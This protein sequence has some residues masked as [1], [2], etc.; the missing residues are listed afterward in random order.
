M[1]KI[2][3]CIN[4]D[5]DD[6]DDDDSDVCAIV[7]AWMQYWWCSS[8]STKEE[9]E[10]T[11]TRSGTEKVSTAIQR[12]LGDETPSSDRRAQPARPE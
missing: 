8:G 9:L 5:D 2:M 3:N 1:M 6:D 12:F 11:R 10:E 7:F 4:N